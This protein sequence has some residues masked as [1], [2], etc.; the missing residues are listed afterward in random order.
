MNELKTELEDSIKKLDFLLAQYQ[1]EIELAR[2]RYDEIDDDVKKQKELENIDSLT[3]KWNEFL[4]QRKEY[5][6]ALQL[7]F[8]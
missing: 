6:D 8:M 2:V 1:Q 3:R 4:A 5:E 7:Q